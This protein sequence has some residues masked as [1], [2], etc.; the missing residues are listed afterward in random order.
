MKQTARALI[1]NPGS[2]CFLALHNHVNPQNFG[3]WGTVGGARDPSDES[4]QACLQRELKEELSGF[5]FEI[6]EEVAV[7]EKNGVQHHFFI[8]QAKHTGFEIRQKHEILDARYFG[9][10]EVEKLALNGKLYFS[11]EDE[12]FKR[13]L[14]PLK[15]ST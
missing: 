12:L 2:E 5:E 1:I 11:N 15:A 9:I 6:F 7:L 14:L 4:L 10:E 8:V 3:K 13:A